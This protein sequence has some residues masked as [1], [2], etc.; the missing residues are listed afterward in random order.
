MTT[1]FV[2]S[3]GGHLAELHALRPRLE[4]IT[5]DREVWVSFDSEQS[6]GLLAGERFIAVRYTAPRDYRNVARNLLTAPRILR[7]EGVD[8]LVTTG[9]AIALSFMPVARALGI[10]THYVESLARFDGPSTTGRAARRI[11]G[12][13][14]YTQTPSWADAH[15]HYAGSVLDGFEVEPVPRDPQVRRVVVTT[16]TSR[17]YPFRRLVERLVDV[18]PGDAEVLWQTGIT[19]V[20]DLGVSPADPIEWA[21]LNRAIERADV[22]VAHAGVGSAIAAL[23]A[24]KCPVLVPRSLAHGENVDDHQR[25]LA[26]ELDARGL[27]IAVESDRLDLAH[28]L[29]A[30]T[31]R[32][33]RVAAPPPFRLH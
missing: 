14:R 24:G 28:L 1:L 22:V 32:T 17:R 8:C 4:G 5:G 19:P 12:V 13:Q 18:L 30:S 33:R 9:A 3:I 7:K 20:G 15:W 27:A 31:R 2:A 29:D 25:Q 26:R 23:E 21:E 16:G 11:P 10:P 6:R